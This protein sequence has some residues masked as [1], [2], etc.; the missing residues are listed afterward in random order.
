MLSAPVPRTCE[1]KKP[2]LVAQGLPSSLALAWW[3]IRY[4]S[5]QADGCP[6]VVK[7]TLYEGSP[8]SAIKKAA[9]L[10]RQLTSCVIGAPLMVW[11]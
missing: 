7:S 4:A 11:I 6:A 1:Q 2:W 5:P 3:A 10:K 8:A 9:M